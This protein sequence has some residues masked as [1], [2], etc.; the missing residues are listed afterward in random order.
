MSVK[1]Y[2]RRL[3]REALKFICS[4]K[5]SSK[6]L[7][8][9]VDA[10]YFNNPVNKVVFNRIM[11]VMRK[12][13]EIVSWRSLIT[14][15]ALPDTARE[16][17]SSYTE[18]VVINKKKM[19]EL[20][21]QLTS[22]R[23]RFIIDELAK[24]A[25]EQQLSGNYDEDALL[26]NLSQ[27][28]LQAR[29]KKD[30]DEPLAFG[31]GS[32]Y[33]KVLEKIKRGDAL[34]TIKIG[35][36][37]WDSVNGGIPSKSVT[38]ITGYTG[39]MK[40]TLSDVIACNMADEGARVGQIS[41]EMGQDEIAI[42]RSARAAR[43]DRTDIMRAVNITPKQ[44]K[45]IEHLLYVQD[46]RWRKRDSGVRT[47]TPKNITK[48]DIF[49]F[50]EPFQYDVVIID[51]VSLVGGIMDAKDFW[52]ELMNF[53]ARAKIFANNNNCRVILLAQADED[54]K[55]KLSKNMMNDADI[56]F[57]IK[58]DPANPDIMEVN[59][60]K[61]RK[62]KPITLLL[63]KEGAYANV[64]DLPEE[65]RVNMSKRQVKNEMKPTK[66]FRVRGEKGKSQ[67]E[68]DIENYLGDDVDFD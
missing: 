57:A 59:V 8:S 46:K 18:K 33:K 35:L 36:E 55:L 47:H 56:V 28:L 7:L 67:E 3:E 2:N 17:L 63:K 43:I 31:V 26:E 66:E 16:A 9:L 45:K 51:Y 30:E 50:L 34:K 25:N 38:L 20:H 29:S 22:Y 15:S 21:R 60:P 24:H 48:D 6:K 68:L 14:D 23:K 62:Q 39:S 37:Q 40:S 52:K 12:E 27:R 5:P 49:T 61:A 42:M 10:S 19:G 58:H 4:G 1:I 32:N 11:K 41:L 54:S 44:W 64:C 53:T 65:E 13:G